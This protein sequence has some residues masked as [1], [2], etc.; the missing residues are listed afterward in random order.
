MPKAEKLTDQIWAEKYRPKTFDE[1]ILKDKETILKYI[2]NPLTMPSFIFYSPTYGTGKTTTARLIANQLGADVLEI[3][4]S[5]DRGID[6]IRNKVLSFASSLSMDLTVKRCIILDEADRLTDEAQDSLKSP[7]EAYSKNC[8]FIFC[9]NDISKIIDAIRSRCVVINFGNLDKQEVVNRLSF[10]AK[11]EEVE[12]TNAQ[13]NELVN[14]HYP[15]MRYMIKNLQHIKTT[16]QVAFTNAN[17]S[18][19][20]N[21]INKQDMTT[22]YNKVYND[23][24]FDILAFNRYFFQKVYQSEKLSPLKRAKIG[25]YLADIEKSHALKI[26]TQIIFLANIDQIMGV[27]KP[28]V[29]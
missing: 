23:S 21:A 19:V 12:L 5:K 14:L 11:K 7:L 28:D 29:K 27:L 6:V 9:C 1:L 18:E 20:I 10:I 4:A 26:N 8:F 25:M 13:F 17:F 16:G 24:T 22:I 3:N 2:E 15:D